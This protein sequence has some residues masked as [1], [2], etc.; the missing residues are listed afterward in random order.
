M[1][2]V[3]E[4]YDTVLY[5][6]FTYPDAHPGQMAVMALLYGLEPAQVETCR[7]L[8]IG[9]NEGANIVPM[10]YAIPG[11]EFVGFD[12]AGLPIAYGQ[13]RIAELGLRNIRLF[14]ADLMDVGGDLG[15]F[16]YIIAHGIYAWV[17]EA[18]RDRV[19]AICKEHLAPNGVA[20]ISYNARPGGH[21]REMMREL[22]QLRAKDFADPKQKVDQ[23]LELVQALVE[24]RPE[25]DAFRRIIEDQAKRMQKGR[26]AAIYHDELNPTYYPLY[27][28]DFVAHA[29]QH[30]LQYLTE[31]VLPPPID[32]CF[33]PALQQVIKAAAGNDL[34][35]QEQMLDFTRMRMFRETLLCHAEVEL[36]REFPAKQIPRLYVASSAISE[37][38]AE[39]G[40]RCFTLP[41]GSPKV[42]C[43]DPA[44]IALMDQLIAT[45]PG[46]LTFDQVFATL[47]AHGKDNPNE[48]P[49][50]LLQMAV[51]RTIELHLWKAPVAAEISSHPRASAI[52]RQEARRHPYTG[53][54]WHFTLELT[55]P[56]GRSLLQMLD[57]T[58]D[59]PA[60]LEAL[61]AAFPET[62]AQELETQ[63]EASLRIL[64]RAAIL[65]A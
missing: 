61:K 62:A 30:G 59:R 1:S 14:Q 6:G 54:L 27:F 11:A 47:K 39:P 37:D 17:P 50:M 5:P 26:M 58:R 15:Q 19:M 36:R 43:D 8:E 46:V 53:T 60:L 3:Q 31:A 12:L 16:D 35:K 23:S 13:E 64:H 40:T 10:A 55:D 63:M 48:V 51:A 65:E 44:T 28:S 2:S 21:I 52:A 24:A 49:M 29:R 38:G 34:I 41:T 7:V 45:W 57:G 33:N 20:F 18:V 22:M 42:D 9:C 4:A 56:V 25:N 32:P